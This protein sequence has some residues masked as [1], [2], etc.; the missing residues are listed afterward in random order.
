MEK[1]ILAA[2][3]SIAGT[4]LSSQEKFLLE[5][6]NPLGITL[7]GRNILNKK[8]LQNLTKEIRETIGRDDILI[9]VDQEGGRIRRLAEPDFSPYAAQAEL[10]EIEERFGK[11]TAEQTMRNHAALISKDLSNT[12][13]N[14]NYAPVLDIAYNDT[15]PALK[16]RCFGNDEKKTATYGRMMIEEYIK[17]GICPCIKHM[18]GHGRAVNDPHLG[19]PVLNYSLE[20]LAKDFYPFQYNNQ[21]P[22]GM[23][24]HIQISA[25]DDTRPVTQSAKAIKTLIRGII[26]FD[27]FLISDAI[28]M[29]ALK[30]SLTEK[31]E[32]SL[33]AGCDAVCYCMGELNGLEELAATRCFMEDKSLIRFVKIINIINNRN[34]DYDYLKIAEDYQKIIGGI[35]KYDERYDATETLHKMKSLN[36]EE[37]IKC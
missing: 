21:A 37:T 3:L 6:A 12:G 34:R 26:G 36:N 17:S 2:M 25:I 9:A 32:K 33:N 14:W 13:I 30:G 23:T 18:P 24:A 28:D 10:G 35:E 31:T 15:T 5:K 4:E 29:H 27:G 7:F 11:G 22:A 20:E 8:Q 19:L 1:P 16:S